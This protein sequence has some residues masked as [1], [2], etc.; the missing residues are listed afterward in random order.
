MISILQP[1]FNFKFYVIVIILF[2]GSSPYIPRIFI[3]CYMFSGSNGSIIAI[4]YVWLLIMRF[5]I[6]I[7]RISA[8]PVVIVCLVPSICCFSAIIVD[9]PVVVLTICSVLVISVVIIILSLSY[10]FIS[11]MNSIEITSTTI[12]LG[13]ISINI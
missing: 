2:I 8:A 11:R 7:L 1:G 6:V 12:S 3:N 4:I 9:V 10:S 13:R 5:S